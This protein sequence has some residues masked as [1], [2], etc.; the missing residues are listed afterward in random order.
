M[1]FKSVEY[2]V[3]C[4][5]NINDVAFGACDGVNYIFVQYSEFLCDRAG[6]GG[7]LVPDDRQLLEM[8]SVLRGGTSNV[9]GEGGPH[10]DIL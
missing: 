3:L 10:Q 5:A 8:A 9:R 1:L 4:F 7:A 6:G 2:G